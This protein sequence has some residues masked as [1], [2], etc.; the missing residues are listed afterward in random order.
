MTHFTNTTKK[1]AIEFLN[2]YEK[3]A[4]EFKFLIANACKDL[5]ENVDLNV[6][7]VSMEIAKELFGADFK[8]G[9]AGYNKEDIDRIFS[10]SFV[11]EWFTLENSRT[12]ALNFA[13]S[14]VDFKKAH[15][16][17]K[18]EALCKEAGKAFF[19]RLHDRRYQAIAN[20]VTEL[21][22]E[23]AIKAKD[24]KG[25]KSIAELMRTFKTQVR[26]KV[27]EGEEVNKAALIAELEEL[28]TFLSSL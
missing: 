14:W 4:K 13:G 17:D 21:R 3:G 19:K 27:A 5:L 22:N 2:S 11:K 16:S 28:K 15:V 26:N 20:T 10:K 25:K 23:N 18:E 24:P 6:Q 12:Y 7:G 9:K 1:Q 8:S